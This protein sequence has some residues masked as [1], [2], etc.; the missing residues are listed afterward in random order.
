MRVR[1]RVRVR[2]RA[3]ARARV[4][5]SDGLLQR[6]ARAGVLG[7]QRAEEHRHQREVR[8]QQRGRARAERGDGA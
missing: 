5:V 8:A 7:G 1:V 2:V 4:R 3:R 6:G